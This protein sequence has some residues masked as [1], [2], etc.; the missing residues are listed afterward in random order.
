[1]LVIVAHFSILIPKQLLIKV[2]KTLIENNMAELG[3]TVLPVLSEP[4][5]QAD[6]AVAGCSSKTEGESPYN[7][8]I[9]RARIKQ[10]FKQLISSQTSFT[11]GVHTITQPSL[12]IMF[13]SRSD[14]Q[15]VGVTGFEHCWK[16]FL[17][18]NKTTKI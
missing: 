2:I 14:R 9:D 10:L 18:L 1:M 16:H 15:L 8:W 6:G 4:N 12:L 5:V 7:R 13:V 17:Q 11:Y 3:V